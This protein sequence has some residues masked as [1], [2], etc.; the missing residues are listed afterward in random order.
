MIR[1]TFLGLVTLFQHRALRVDSNS[2]FGTSFPDLV[3]QHLCLYGDARSDQQAGRFADEAAWDESKMVF[4]SFVKDRVA[5]IG[6][7]SSS[8]ADVGLVLQG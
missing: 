4:S 6:S 5:G 2:V 8:D 3:H 7:V 1:V